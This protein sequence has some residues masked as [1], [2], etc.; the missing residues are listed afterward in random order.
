MENENEKKISRFLTYKVL[1]I[2]LVLFV[3][4]RPWFNPQQSDHFSWI[5]CL[6]LV[7]YTAWKDHKEG[8]FDKVTILYII[9]SLLIIGAMVYLLLTCA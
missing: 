2:E 8:T 6:I 4:T 7:V 3:A 5:I 9:L 1:L